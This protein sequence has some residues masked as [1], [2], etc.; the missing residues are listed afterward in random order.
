MIENHDQNIGLV[1]K[2]VADFTKDL[3]GIQSEL[4]SAKVIWN[5]FWGRSKGFIDISDFAFMDISEFT[6]QR[7]NFEVISDAK[8]FLSLPA[9]QVQK[10]SSSSETAI[11][12]IEGM[13]TK[14]S[15]HV[16][17]EVSRCRK[18]CSVDHA[19]GSQR[20]SN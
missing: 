15:V 7:N 19:D 10:L 20:N 17:H 1:K 16:C 18:F 9:L 2:Y 12:S 5:N 8:L 3:N 6:K 4:R 14:I 11:S 13:R